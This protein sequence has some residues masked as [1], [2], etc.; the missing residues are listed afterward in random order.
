MAAT[1][2]HLQNGPCTDTHIQY[3]L[4]LQSPLNP[5]IE[6]VH[7][8]GRDQSQAHIDILMEEARVSL[9]FLSGNNARCL[10]VCGLFKSSHCA[11]TSGTEIP[12]F[13][14]WSCFHTADKPNIAANKP[15][16]WC[17]SMVPVLTLMNLLQ[18]LYELDS[19]PCKEWRG[20]SFGT[21]SE[22]Y[23]LLP[24]LLPCSWPCVYAPL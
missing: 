14:G 15:Q 1:H 13:T 3:L 12:P 19:R 18:F 20:L 2:H 16:V 9:S 24:L 21:N 22:S 7:P 5:H 4:N 6:N 23:S 17:W 8:F 10:Q 11:Q